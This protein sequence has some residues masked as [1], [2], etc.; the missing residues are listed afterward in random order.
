MATNLINNGVELKAN[1]GT[2]SLNF[3]WANFSSFVEDVERDT[4]AEAIG[5]EALD[6]FIVNLL[7]LEGVELKTLQLLQRSVAYLSIYNWSQTALFQFEDKALFLAKTTNGA[8]PSDKKL[9]DLRTY[10]EE[11]GYNYLDR[12]IDLLENNLEVFAAYADSPA[13][14]SNHR[15]FIKTAAEFSKIRTINNSRLT[16][17]SMYSVMLDVQSERLPNF[18]TQ[19]YYE[20][21]LEKYLDDDLTADEKKVLPYVQKAV[22]M[23][24]ISEACKSL[25]VEISAKGLFINRFGNSVDYEQKDAASQAQQDKLQGDYADKGDQALNKLK[26]YLVDNALLLPG[27]IAPVVVDIPL[28]DQCSGLFYM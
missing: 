20:I 9:R 8:I 25:P 14:I 28:N 4:I 22:A 13:R 21:F 2:V 5:Q 23:L 11:K 27:Y 17:L 19:A 7:T 3:T 15:A 24:T 10:C 1:F 16:F 26:A 12:A 6:Y 18:M